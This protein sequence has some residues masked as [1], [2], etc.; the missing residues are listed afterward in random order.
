MF[1]VNR[2]NEQHEEEEIGREK[3]QEQDKRQKKE[4]EGVRRR[5]TN[6]KTLVQ[7]EHPRRRM[8]EV[9]DT[10]C[11]GI[12]KKG[13]TFKKQGRPAKAPTCMQM[14]SALSF[15]NSGNNPPGSFLATAR[16]PGGGSVKKKRTIIIRCDASSACTTVYIPR[17]DSQF[18]GHGLQGARVRAKGVLQSSTQWTHGE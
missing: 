14:T 15:S 4:S 17:Y 7:T 10:K 5:T 11:I 3:Q 18:R 13:L 6:C 2:K 12:D 1:P 16:I 8:R 9:A